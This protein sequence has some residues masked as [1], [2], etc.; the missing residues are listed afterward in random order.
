MKRDYLLTET[1]IQIRCYLVLLMISLNVSGQ[2]LT[3]DKPENIGLSSDR[4][5]RIDNV[6]NEGIMGDKFG[7][8]FGIRT[9]RGVYDELESIGTFGWDGAFYTRFWVDPNEDLIGIFL[10]QVDNYWSENLIGKFRV[11]VYQSISD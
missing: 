10:S 6:M 1:S 4:L 9:E 7:L 5:M 11:L 2:K 8:G 3:V